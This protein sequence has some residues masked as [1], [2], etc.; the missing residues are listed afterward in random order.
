MN[1]SLD[2]SAYIR[3]ASDTMISRIPKSTSIISFSL[4]IVE[5]TAAKASSELVPFRSL[6]SPQNSVYS[7]EAAIAILN[8]L[9]SLFMTFFDF[10]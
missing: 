6:L 7:P 3:D 10:L 1:G 4:L 5:T 2:L 9:A 8:D